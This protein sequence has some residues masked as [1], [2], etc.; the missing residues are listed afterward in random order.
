MN[1]Y[2]GYY[3]S[4]IGWL[5]IVCNENCLL[6]IN[7]VN[8]KKEGNYN[9]FVK[10]TIVQLDEYFKGIRK[11]FDIPLQVQGTS[12]Q[13]Q[14]W[15][16]LLTIPYGKTASYKDIATAIKN[17]KAVRAVGSANGKNKIPIVIPCHRIINFNGKLGGY[18]GELWRKEKL[19]EIENAKNN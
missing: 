15:N 9:G 2:K 5:E 12:F 6:E 8:E 19:L 10:Q 1:T 14:V 4:V 13:K 18:A 17:D 16:A 11:T 7:F 3:H